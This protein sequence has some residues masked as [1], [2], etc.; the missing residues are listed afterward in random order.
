MSAVDLVATGGAPSTMVAGLRLTDAVIEIVRPSPATAGV[1]VE[2]LWSADED[3]ADVRVRP[4]GAGAMS[5]AHRTSSSSRTTRRS[6]GLL[7]AHL[8]ARGYR[9]TV[10]PTAESATGAPG[11]T[12]FAR[13]SCCSTS[14]CPARPAGPSCGARRSR[15]P[16]D[17]RSSSP[18]RCRSVR[19]GCASSASP[20]YLPKPFAMDTLGTTL[21]RLLH[22]RGE[23]N[24]THD[25]PADRT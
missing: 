16:A 1:V 8:R 6:A 18:A 10:A 24:G 4:R 22:R 2:P 25:R 14:T 11:R 12:A 5:D 7:S 13:T 19:P 20:G 23:G 21:D 17:H 3:T 9:V 15:R